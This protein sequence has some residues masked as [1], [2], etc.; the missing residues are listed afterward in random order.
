MAQAVQA[1]LTA[2]GQ[3][4]NGE[5]T[6]EAFCGIDMAQSI[7]CVSW[8]YGVSSPTEPQTGLSA[9]RRSH[10]PIV[11]TK[12]IDASSPLLFKACCQNVRIEG[13]FMFFRPSIDGTGDT[14]HFYSV[15]ITGGRI[16]RIKQTSP[17]V[18]EPGASTTPPMETIAITF[19]QIMP[20]YERG[21]ACHTDS[22]KGN[23]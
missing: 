3:P 15:E 23:S 14:E 12:R 10:D 21:G 9:G 13:V 16:A 20:R 11:I 7:E 4:I 5:S 17:N 1:F 6:Q 18:E 2:N 8:D 19:S 22:W